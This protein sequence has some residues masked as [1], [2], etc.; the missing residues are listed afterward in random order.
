MDAVIVT[1]ASAK[2]IAA[3]VLAVQERRGPDQE[4][5]AYLAERKEALEEVQRREDGPPLAK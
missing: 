5:L 4:T 1:N 3:L 2:E